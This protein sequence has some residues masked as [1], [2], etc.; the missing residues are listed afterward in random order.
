M[1]ID[2]FMSDLDLNVEGDDGTEELYVHLYQKSAGSAS[3]VTESAMEVDEDIADDLEVFPDTD[4]HNSNKRSDEESARIDE[5]LEEAHTRVKNYCDLHFNQPE[6]KHEDKKKRIH[7]K[8]K[9]EQIGMFIDLIAAGSDVKSACNSTGI[10]LH[11]DYNYRKKYREDPELYI[12]ER[13]TA[14]LAQVLED[15]TNHFSDENIQVSKSALH[16]FMREKCALSMKR[17][18]KIPARRNHIDVIT[19]RR[20]SVEEWIANEDMDFEKNCVFIDEAGF[21]I[22]IT[23]NRGWSKKG[24]PA[25]AIV[26]TSRSTSITI[27]GAISTDGVI[28]ISL[29]KPTSTTGSKKRK[30]NG[31]E[32]VVNGRVG[33]R[34][35]HFM[36]YLNSMMDCLD[37]NGSQGYYLVMDNAPIHKPIAIRALIEERGYKCVYLPPYS[38]FLN[39][40]EEFWSKVKSGIKRNPLDTGDLLTPRIMESVTNVTLQDCRGWIRHSVKAH[41]KEVTEVGTSQIDVANGAKSGTYRSYKNEDK[42]ALL[43]IDEKG[44][45]V[46]SAALKLNIPPTTARNWLKKEEQ[47]TEVEVAG[48]KTGSGRPAGRPT[49]FNDDHKEYLT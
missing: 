43:L 49:A 45:R 46:R 26:P 39:P 1:S 31:K 11:S 40:I 32:V 13:P 48:R 20:E 23:R 29:R 33:T 42:E 15:L 7:M 8:Y 9:D 16:R 6:F 10:R 47:N 19:Q 4:H 14:V 17:L 18:E 5:T 30:V 28:A 21:N 2:V 25:K 44:C 41:K 3:S 27:L 38:P 24:K 36:S 34:S 35:S 37:R 22:N 12:D